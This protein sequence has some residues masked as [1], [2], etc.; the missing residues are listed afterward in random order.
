M[1][2]ERIVRRTPYF[3]LC[4]TTLHKE[5][6]VRSLEACV[7]SAFQNPEHKL[8]QPNLATLLREGQDD[9]GTANAGNGQR[10]TKRN[11][12]GTLNVAMPTL[13]KLAIG[14]PGSSSSNIMTKVC[15]MAAKALLAE[16]AGGDAAVEGE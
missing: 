11:A 4:F 13:P 5:R 10:G 14:R 7:N 9:N 8:F 2:F 12:A 15:E 3:G 1:A 16:V 6:L